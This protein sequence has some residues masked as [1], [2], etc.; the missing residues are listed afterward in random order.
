MRISNN[1]HA[2]VGILAGALVLVAAGGASGAAAIGNARAESGAH[3]GCVGSSGLLR[4]VAT[5]ESCKRN[6]APITWSQTGP[7]GPQ[8]PAG[9]PGPRGEPGPAQPPR[10]VMDRAA[11]TPDGDRTD[12]LPIVSVE[13]GAGKWLVTGTVD[14]HAP[15][16]GGF[17]ACRVGQN[18]DLVGLDGA[19]VGTT[20]VSSGWSSLTIQHLHTSTASGTVVLMCEGPDR[21]GSGPGLVR[22]FNT[23]LTAIEVS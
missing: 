16:T 4:V 13:L 6:E 8:G 5:G 19:D 20:S 23:R 2:R 21:P 14:L 1:G 18:E 7:P 10:L 9:E 11:P 15:A 22:V 12:G 3:H 17:V